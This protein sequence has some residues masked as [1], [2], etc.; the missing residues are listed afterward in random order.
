MCRCSLIDVASLLD[1]P[2]EAIV[3]ER[4]GFAEVGRAGRALDGVGRWPS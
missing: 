1:S 4:I 2:G 3:I